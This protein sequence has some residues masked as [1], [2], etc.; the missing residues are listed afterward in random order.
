LQRL[1]LSLDTFNSTMANLAQADLPAPL[2]TPPQSVDAE[3]SASKPLKQWVVGADAG[4]EETPEP[5]PPKG[6]KGKAQAEVSHFGLKHSNPEA[7]ELAQKIAERFETGLAFYLSQDPSRI[8]DV[9]ALADKLTPDMVDPNQLAQKMHRWFK[10]HKLVR[11]AELATRLP[12]SVLLHVLPPASTDPDTP[13][14]LINRQRVKAWRDAI[15]SG[16][17]L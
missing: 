5:M 14:P 16:K 10:R 13:S 11:L 4:E 9:Q 17:S 7:E 3:E 12:V 6:K 2:A 8:D 1:Q 15:V